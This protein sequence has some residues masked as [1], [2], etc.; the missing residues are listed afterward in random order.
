MCQ[1][2]IGSGCVKEQSD[3]LY[4]Y[5][6]S[7]RVRNHNV[8]RS[9][10]Q[11]SLPPSQNPPIHNAPQRGWKNA[12]SIAGPGHVPASP[13]PT[14]KAAAPKTN[15]LSTSLNVFVG[16]A[17][18]SANDGG[19]FNPTSWFSMRLGSTPKSI[20]RPS[21]GSQYCITGKEKKDVTLAEL[22]IPD[23]CRPRAK[24][25]P[26]KNCVAR[27]AGVRGSAVCGFVL[28]VRGVVLKLVALVVCEAVAL[29]TN[30]GTVRAANMLSA[31]IMKRDVVVS[32]VG[33]T[34][35]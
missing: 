2:I 1:K 14:P 5:L 16:N 19:V 17:N 23:M 31:A 4:G 11:P 20:T 28:L 7:K 29:A 21:D 34:G 6:R 15:F 25:R 22:D 12:L 10:H 24:R 27:R 13:K 32:R 18:L 8:K 9:H 3:I 30:V 33:Y 26:V 35:L